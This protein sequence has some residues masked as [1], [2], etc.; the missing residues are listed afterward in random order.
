MWHARMLITTHGT[1]LRRSVRAYRSTNSECACVTFPDLEYK[2]MTFDCVERFGYGYHACE[3]RNFGGIEW[4]SKFLGIG[5]SRQA[6][7]DFLL[8]IS[9]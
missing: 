7:P 4:D 2:G 3:C 1:L 6:V 9:L 8:F 5:T